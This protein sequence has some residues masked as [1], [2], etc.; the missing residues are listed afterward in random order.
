MHANELGRPRADLTGS[1]RRSGCMGRVLVVCALALGVSACS[2]AMPDFSAANIPML[3]GFGKEEQVETGYEVVLAKQAASLN[4]NS[5][6]EAM[7]RDALDLARQKRFAEATS[8]LAELRESQPR[9]SEGYQASTA[10]MALLA[11]KA[12]DF[13]MFRRLGRQ[14]DRSLGLPVRVD[15]AYVEVISLYR[16][17]VGKNLP[18]NAPD[19]IK[20]LAA[21]YF[22]GTGTQSQKETKT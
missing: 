4:P 20:K 10:T 15:G 12:G 3:G 11:L 21:K 22:E 2:T 7:V 8:I 16:A 1:S 9:P 17:A 18:V 5:P 19:G 6:V 14:L 13:P